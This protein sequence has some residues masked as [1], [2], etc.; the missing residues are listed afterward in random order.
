MRCVRAR[1]AGEPCSSDEGCPSGSTCLA[2]HCQRAVSASPSSAGS[3][4]VGYRS[5]ISQNIKLVTF[6]HDNFASKSSVVVSASITETARPTTKCAILRAPL[7]DGFC[8][9]GARIVL[10]KAYS[11]IR[12][13]FPSFAKASIYGEFF[14]FQCMDFLLTDF[15]CED[16]IDCSQK[17]CKKKNGKCP[18]LTVKIGR[19]AF[20]ELFLFSFRYAKGA[21]AFYAVAA[22]RTKTAVGVNYAPSLACAPPRRA[23]TT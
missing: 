6:S 11:A 21:L 14:T 4:V 2:N 19:A 23:P 12:T 3:V 10:A 18:Q 16:D 17:K 15:N 5:L 20:H 1:C 8:A 13:S 7:V 22:A 9:R